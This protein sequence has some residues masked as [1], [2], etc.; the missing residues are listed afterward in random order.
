MDFMRFAALLS[1][2]ILPLVALLVMLAGSNRPNDAI[3]GVAV[4]LA[5]FP[6]WVG[7]LGVACLVMIPV[8]IWRL[9]DRCAQKTAFKTTP[10]RPLW[11]QWIDG[12]YS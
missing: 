2:C 8:W 3:W 10:Q 6:I 12:P 1:L 9:L 11:D 5:L 7:T 4:F